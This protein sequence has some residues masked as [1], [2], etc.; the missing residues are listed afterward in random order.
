MMVLVL[1]VVVELRMELTVKVVLVVV[2]VVLGVVVL[3][4]AVV[5][6]NVVVE[7]ETSVVVIQGSGQRVPRSL[8]RRSWKASK[9]EDG[10]RP[11]YHS[12]CLLMPVFMAQSTFWKHFSPSTAVWQPSPERSSSQL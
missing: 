12:G 6:A 10:V 2:A 8:L 3:V 4:L 5:T 9:L 1:V 7:V 11:G